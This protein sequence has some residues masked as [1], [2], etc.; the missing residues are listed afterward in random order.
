MSN[1]TRTLAVIPARYASTPLSPGKV[2]AQLC[3]KP[4]IQHVYE[5]AAASIADEVLVAA[6]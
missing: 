4:M 1:T 5:K 3:G 2:L 6:R